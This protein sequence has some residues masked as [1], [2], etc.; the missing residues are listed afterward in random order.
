M[1]SNIVLDT[2]AL[3]ILYMGEEG[4]EHVAGLLKQVLDRKIKGYMNVV[5]LAELY[6]IL[7]RKSKKVAEEKERN[8]RSFGVKIV[9]V[10]D[11]ALWKEAAML[12]ANHSLSLA[13][14][15][16]AATAKTL[17]SKL[18]TGADPEFDGIDNVQIERVGARR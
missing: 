17:R 14:A 7:G 5:N 12:K 15:F 18:V 9:S 2:Q 10:K 8:V 4:S 16:A 6:Y 3:L 13:D 11:N 1:S